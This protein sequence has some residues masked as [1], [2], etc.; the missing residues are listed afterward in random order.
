MLITGASRLCYCKK[1]S[2]TRADSDCLKVCISGII[3]ICTEYISTLNFIFTHR[4]PASLIRHRM[5]HCR[6]LIYSPSIKKKPF[7]IFYWYLLSTEYY[8]ALCWSVELDIT[9][10][11]QLICCICL[12]P[13]LT[14]W[15][16]VTHIRV[17][18]STIIG[19]DNGLSPDWHQAIIWTN[20][21]ILSIRTIR[22][23]FSKILSKIHTFS[24]KKMHWIMSS[25][26][27]RPFLS[28]PQCVKYC[29]I[30]LVIDRTDR[31]GVERL[32]IESSHL[33]DLQLPPDLM[34][35]PKQ[36]HPYHRLLLRSMT[37]GCGVAATRRGIARKLCKLR[38]RYQ[39]MLYI[40]WMYFYG[41]NV[42][43]IK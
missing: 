5:V 21:G 16:Q 37:Y 32:V 41:I 19:S 22:T 7:I 27:W 42:T 26:N 17:S 15:G 38:Q 35:I 6:C 25:G 30:F 43:M 12:I 1:A 33:R 9:M 13:C 18:N 28:R 24:F 4:W 40:C 39:K 8:H 29:F 14:H 2:S 3:P 11:H 20:A 23:N 31:I 10:F 36:L 34:P